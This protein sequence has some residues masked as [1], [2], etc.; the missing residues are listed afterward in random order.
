VPAS[1]SRRVVH[2]VLLVVAVVVLLVVVVA[3]VI[4]LSV[5]SGLGRVPLSP[6]PAS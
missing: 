5:I 1:R 6:W 3:A 4:Y 2:D